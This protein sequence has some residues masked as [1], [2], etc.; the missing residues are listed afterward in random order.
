MEDEYM[1]KNTVI[2]IITFPVIV[3]WKFV[4]LV[5][6]VTAALMSMIA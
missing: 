1:K 4:M 2:K 6:K 3:L 5:V